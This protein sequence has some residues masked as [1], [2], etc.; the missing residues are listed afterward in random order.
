[1]TAPTASSG[2][3]ARRRSGPMTSTDGTSSTG[4][5]ASTA[6]PTAAM[7]PSD[8]QRRMR[9][10]RA[11]RDGRSHGTT[12]ASTTSPTASMASAARPSIG[13]PSADHAAHSAATAAS[14]CVAPTTTKAAPS[15]RRR[16]RDS[17]S[18]PAGM[19]AQPIT[20]STR[21]HQLRPSGSRPSLASRS[22]STV[23]APAAA[24][25][26]A[27]E[28]ANLV[29]NRSRPTPTTAVSPRTGLARTG[30]RSRRAPKSSLGTRANGH[31]DTGRTSVDVSG[32]FRSAEGRQS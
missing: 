22:T 31:Q 21:I 9:S 10:S 28:T 15:H 13:S 3:V 8:S 27:E 16:G 7:T 18:A 11:L 19:N 20:T 26:T 32:R 14:T 6:P 29:T 1:M 17:K 4:A 24:T 25:T 5:I 30:P 12:P 2:T 23:T